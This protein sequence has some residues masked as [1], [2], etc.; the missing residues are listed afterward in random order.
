M[1]KAH[2]NI[3][4]W[5]LERGRV[6]RKRTRSKKLGNKKS[7]DEDWQHKVMWCQVLQIKPRSQRWKPKPSQCYDICAFLLCVTLHPHFIL[8]GKCCRIRNNF[9]FFCFCFSLTC[10]A[11]LAAVVVVALKGLFRQ[12]NRL[13]QLWRMCKPDA[14]SLL[15]SLL[16]H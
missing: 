1:C 2:H 5:L 10:Q 14:V 12:F 9:F 8:C 3:Y 4:S 11:I 6:W 15:K 13:V 16:F 7:K